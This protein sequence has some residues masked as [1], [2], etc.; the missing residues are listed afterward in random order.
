VPEPDDLS[1][2]A[3]ISQPVILFPKWTDT[4][5][6]TVEGCIVERR[7]SQAQSTDSDIPA[8]RLKIV[9]AKP[10][11]F[12]TIEVAGYKIRVCSFCGKHFRDSSNFSKHVRIH[13]G[14]KPYGC[15]YCK[16]RF[17]DATNCHRH[18]ALCFFKTNVKIVKIDG[19]GNVIG[20]SSADESV[21]A[22]CEPSSPC[23]QEESTD[24]EN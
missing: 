22:E 12:T 13:T 10:K 24:E 6:V 11:P 18:K 1:Q 23:S 8:P 9:D 16:K 7:P 4:A 2:L 21:V 20:T 5:L 3:L 14:E 17:S 19:E 15:E